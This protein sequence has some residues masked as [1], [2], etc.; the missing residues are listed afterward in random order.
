[1]VWWDPSVLHLGV[2]SNDGL[3]RDD[4]IVK[5]VAPALVAEDR[6][7][8]DRWR[9]ARDEAGAAGRRPSLD[10]ASVRQRA[11]AGMTPGDGAIAPESI[12][13]VEI[14][15]GEAWIRR[16]DGRGPAFG[17]LVHAVLAT[18]PLDADRA[19]VARTAEA[20]ARLIGAADADVAAAVDTVA[21]ALTAPLLAEAHL[22]AA[23]GRCRRE[24]PVTVGLPDGTLADGIVDLAFERDGT[25]TVVDYKTDREIADEGEEQYRRQVAMYATAVA[26]ATGQPACGVLLRV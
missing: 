25:W 22:A 18:V 24:V 13:V 19:V 9:A 17:A 16:I 4:L 15:S 1:V 23:D 11:A 5:T 3:R 2:E 14:E 12:R 10:V 6:R 8:Y 21:H 26:R 20:E 7:A